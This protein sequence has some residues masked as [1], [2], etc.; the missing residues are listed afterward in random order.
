MEQI[1]HKIFS[2][3]EINLLGTRLLYNIY[4]GRYKYYPRGIGFGALKGK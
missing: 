4:S 3:P 2:D 1:L